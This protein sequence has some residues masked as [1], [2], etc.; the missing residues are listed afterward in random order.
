MSR[1][2]QGCSKLLLSLQ[3][4]SFKSGNQGGFRVNVMLQ[5]SHIR[6]NVSED[7]SA[8]ADK[9]LGSKGRQ[10]LCSI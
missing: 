10:I 3:L 5:L 7:S 1:A 6:V 8:L 9:F 2:Q 4:E